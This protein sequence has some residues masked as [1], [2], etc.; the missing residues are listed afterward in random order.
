MLFSHFATP[1]T[2]ARQ[3]SCPSQSRGV[4]SGSCPMSWWCYPT[5]SFSVI[6][7]SSY[8]QSFPASGS[9]LMNWFFVS[10]DQSIGTSASVLAMNIQG[11]FP[12]GLTGLLSME[13][14]GLTSLPYHHS[15]RASVLWHSAFFMVQLSHPHMTK[16]CTAPIMLRMLMMGEALGVQARAKPRAP[17]PS[18]LTLWEVTRVFLP[19]WFMSIQDSI[20]DVL[21]I[22]P[23]TA[24][25]LTSLFHFR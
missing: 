20:R 16:N 8:L 10:G 19:I 11:W 6:P 24:I 12:L 22:I 18:D 2:A 7:F 25:K 14:Q 1:W 3:A 15:S 13:S 4:C 9:F 5:I 21:P 23:V 17:S